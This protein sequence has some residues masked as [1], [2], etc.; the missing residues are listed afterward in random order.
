MAHHPL[1][2]FRLYVQKRKIKLTIIMKGGTFLLNTCRFLPSEG[3]AFTVIHL[4][5]PIFHLLF[6]RQE[7]TWVSL[8]ERVGKAQPGPFANHFP[9]LAG[10]P[11]ESVCLALPLCCGKELSQARE[12]CRLPTSTG[13]R[14]VS[15]DGRLFAKMVIIIPCLVP[16]PVK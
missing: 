10:M 11:T 8:A 7:R 6:P 1:G 3:S 12:S 16:S 13:S 14:W 15:L 4:D 5:S 9:L 2:S